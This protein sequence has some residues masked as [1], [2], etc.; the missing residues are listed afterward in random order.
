MIQLIYL[1]LKMRRTLIINNIR[2]Q[3]FVNTNNENPPNTVADMSSLIL[4]SNFRGILEIF[5][6]S[7]F[8]GKSNEPEV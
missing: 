3:F 5:E 2:F 1:I 7:V 8:L 6:F 4:K